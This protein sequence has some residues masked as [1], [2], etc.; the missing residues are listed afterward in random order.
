MLAC[1]LVTGSPAIAERSEHADRRV[2]HPRHTSGDEPGWIAPDV[3]GRLGASQRSSVITRAV[4]PGVTYT[5]WTQTDA[6]GP[7]Q[8]HLLTL[9]PRTPGL[10][11]DYA[12]SGTVRGVA[13]VPDILARGGA[14]AGVNGDF[15]DI[16]RTGAPL[17][18]GKDRAHGV[19]HGRTSGWNSAFY[20]DHRGRPRIGELPLDLRVRH[21]PE[22][23]LTTLNSPYVPADSVGYYTPRWGPTAG[24]AVTQGQRTKVRAVW[25]KHHRVVRVATRLKAGKVIPGGVLIG[26]GAGVRQLRGLKKGMRVVVRAALRGHPRMAIT[27]N[28]LLVT[29]GVVSVIDNRVMHPRT[30]IGVDNDTGEILLLVIDG[31]RAGSRGYTMLELAN[32]MVDLGADQALNLDGGGSSTMVARGLEGRNRVVNTPSDGFL[33]RVANALEVTYRKPKG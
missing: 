13:T 18:L 3:V 16:G 2:L 7:I 17:G 6:R 5:R 15:Y 32:L 12:D 11:L 14:V 31:R 28:Q 25:I 21:H 22:I 4:V 29:D 30:A 1:A 10:R 27:G 20:L 23:T 8:A 33:R 19:L 9:D 26:R 24:Y